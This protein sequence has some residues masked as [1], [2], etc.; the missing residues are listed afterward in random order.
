[1]ATWGNKDQRWHMQKIKAARYTGFEVG[2]TNI[3][4]DYYFSV[5]DDYNLGK[6]A[7]FFL[8][9]EWSDLNEW[10]RVGYIDML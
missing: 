7:K 10:V 6:F 5:F 8:L 1:M 3:L 9:S 2:E 4:L